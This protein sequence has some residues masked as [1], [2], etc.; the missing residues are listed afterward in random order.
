LIKRVL[1]LSVLLLAIIPLLSC[2][3]PLDAYET[4]IKERDDAKAELQQAKSE[5]DSVSTELSRIK[6]GMQVQGSPTETASLIM[7]LASR[8][9]LAEQIIAFDST[10]VKVLRT[11]NELKDEE[12]ARKLESEALVIFKS[13]DPLVRDIAD[14]QLSRAWEETW[15]QPARLQA[16]KSNRP[17]YIVSGWAKFMDRLCTLLREDI[18]RLNPR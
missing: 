18:E 17:G 4:A 1:W 2:G 11:R 9:A 12:T 13:F 15:P 6:L 10:R 5:L 8:A 3:I 7:S 16:E 14:S